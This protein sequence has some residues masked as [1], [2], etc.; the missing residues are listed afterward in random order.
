MA[1]FHPAERPRGLRHLRH[2][3]PLA[4][5]ALLLAACEAPL[6]PP[7]T[8]SPPEPPPPAT[9]T[10]P[11]PPPGPTPPVARAVPT[12]VK[13]HG[14]ELVDEYAWLRNKGTPEVVAYLEAENAYTTAQLKGTEPLQET[15]Y[16][17]M[18]A[19]IQETDQTA[20]Y[21][22]GDYFYYTRYEEG[23]QYPIH[24]RKRKSLDAPEVV[25]LDLNEI[26]KREKFV[27]VGPTA[28][29]DDGNLYAYGL[30]TTGFRQYVLH[31][32]DLRKNELLAESIPRVDSVAFAKGKAQI[33]Y[34]VED[35][36][37]KRPH[38]LYRHEIGKGKGGEDAD[39][40]LFDEKDERFDLEVSRSQDREVLF[41]ESH[42]KTSSEVRWVRADHPDGKLA[43]V[44]PR[45]PDHEYEVEHRGQRFYVRTNCGGR[46]FRLVTTKVGDASRE[47]WKEIVPHRPAVM[48]E[49]VEV[50]KGFTVLHE[51]EGGLQRLRL[52]DDKDREILASVPFPEKVSSIRRA[53]NAEWD[54]PAYRARYESPITPV[55][56]Y[57]Y[58]VKKK[59][60]TLKKRDVV[61]GY[62]PA[63]Y[64][65]ERTEAT[66]SDGV[67]VPV[68]LVRRRDVERKGPSPALLYAY[69]SYGISVPL[70]FSGGRVSLLD[71]GLVFAL[72]HIR[73]GGDLGKPWHDHGRMMEKRNTFT[74][75]VAVAEDLIRRGVTA[76][77][78]LAIQ[79]ASAGGLLM[80]AVVNLRPD[81]FKA[82]VAGVP[83]VDVIN[84]MLD[85][86][87]PLT[88]GEF[89]EWGNPKVKEQYEYMVTYSPYDNLAKKAYPAILVRSAYNDSQVMYWEPAK[90]VARLRA[91]KTD[92]NPLYLRMNMEPAGHGGASGRYSRLRET[93]FD[94]AFVLTELGIT[95]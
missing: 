21:K 84:T 77:D 86:T 25:I 92:Q 71:R 51:R 33:L 62:D 82:V 61:K 16:Q 29:S 3:R 79:G 45:E 40:L 81:L 15:L 38:R 50:F 68:T 12:T 37:T 91:L 35:A 23:K 27:S 67:K 57:D 2:L 42:S 94:Y 11:T 8:P 93:A 65:V 36:T 69:G 58:D 39:P 28:V 26:A 60:L 54:P 56:I 63:R 6:P 75:F 49:G 9:A 70:G 76:S 14:H 31:V 85:E 72:A 1:I 10:A 20:P 66:A 95:K 83:F 90:Y 32:K 22:D 24:C 19:R 73:G 4:L 64:E 80:G 52:L 34:T 53:D 43:V 7:A 17:E 74:D 59:T 89:E 18:K 78:R 13:I 88:V 5:A 87:L 41:A 44:L 55:S 47:H 48:L 30:D 46:N